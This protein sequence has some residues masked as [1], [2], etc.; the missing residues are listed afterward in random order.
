M[1]SSLKIFDAIIFGFDVHHQKEII[2]LFFDKNAAL[3]LQLKKVLPIKWSASK[4]CWY[5]LD[6]PQ[7][8]KALGLPVKA[9]ETSFVMKLEEP[10]KAYLQQMA[11]VLVLKGMSSNTQNTYLNEVF[12]FFT[13]LG[14]TDAKILD[15]KRLSGYIL[16]CHRVLKLSENTIHSRMN[17]LKFLYEKVLKN[18]TLINNIPRP[19]R[20]KMLPKVLSKQEVIK[21]IAVC[22]NLKHRL[23]IKLIY[24]LGLRVSE[25]VNLKIADIDSGSMNVHIVNAKGKKD[26]YIPLPATILEELRSYYVLFAPKVYL[27]EGPA[28]GA[29]KVRSVQAVFKQ[30]MKRAGIIKQIGVHGLRHSYATHL[31]EQGADIRF[32]QKLLGHNSIK[33]TELYTHVSHVQL[34][35]IKSPLD[36]L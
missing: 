36:S 20:K 1:R 27:F 33:T 12:N 30:N 10:N 15:T 19:K 5:G 29:Y 26:R 32:I 4:K 8:R 11:D 17:A 3:S 23:I 21:L 31:L 18:G 35:N 9:I 25:V 34:N 22:E 6:M 24:G 13:T 28:G 16:Y 14:A 2:T 7:Y